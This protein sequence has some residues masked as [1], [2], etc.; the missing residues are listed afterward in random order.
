LFFLEK[1]FYVGPW[2][3]VSTT[4]GVIE[5]I[6]VLDLGP[7]VLGDWMGLL[8]VWVPGILAHERVVLVYGWVWENRVEILRLLRGLLLLIGNEL[9]IIIAYEIWGLLGLVPLV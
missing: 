7:L 1:K 4:V 6:L 3:G 9:D 2:V 8:L 5:R